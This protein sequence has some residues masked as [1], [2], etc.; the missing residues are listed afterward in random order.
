MNQAIT[1]LTDGGDTVRDLTEGHRS[2]STHI[3]DWFHIAMRLTVLGQMGKSVEVEQK[4][5]K[6]EEELVR[7]KWF[8]LPQQYL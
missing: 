1:F 5:E 3:L 8:R 7:V 6:F 2:Q 4:G